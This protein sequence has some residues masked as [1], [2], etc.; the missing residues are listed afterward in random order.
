MKHPTQQAQG[1]AAGGA[2]IQR[3]TSGTP[4]LKDFFGGWLDSVA[5]ELS[6]PTTSSRARGSGFKH[7]ITANDMVRV[8]RATV[9]ESSA[10]RHWPPDVVAQFLTAEVIK[11]KN[12]RG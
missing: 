10:H 3:V 6:K 5:P 12:T 8:N 2:N 9:R 1:V 4:S 11:R 7:S